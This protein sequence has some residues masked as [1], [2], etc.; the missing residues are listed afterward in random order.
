MIVY[1][2]EKSGGIYA[3]PVFAEIGESWEI[4]SVVLDKD[5]EHLILLPIKAKSKNIHFNYIYIDENVQDG[6]IEENELC[7]FPEI[8]NNKT[9][10]EDLKNG[11]EIPI[12]NLD[13]VKQYNLPLPV[14]DEFSVRNEK[15]NE[16]FD[17]ICWGLHD[18]HIEKIER[19]E[20]DLIINFDTT[21]DKHIVMTFTNVEEEQHLEDVNCI[22][23]SS[24]EFING[25]V[26]WFVVGGYNSNWDGIDEDVYIVAKSISWKLIID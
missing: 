6:W 22:L 25:K 21:W 12:N 3:S 1:I 15:D 5:N 10:I 19:T 24:F 26:K 20:K 18:A 9:L 23:A 14:I 17:T 11:K 13:C 4:K 7:G 16:T 2:R 8:I